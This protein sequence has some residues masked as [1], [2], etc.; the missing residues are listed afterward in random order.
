[1]R[2]AI[3][4][5]AARAFR[6]G[7][8][9]GTSTREI[10]SALGMTKGNLYYYFR[11][12]EQ[13]LFACHDRSLDLMLGCLEEVERSGLPPEE[14]LRQLIRRHVEVMI[15]ELGGSAMALEFGSLSPPLL[16]RVIAKRDLY[17]AGFRRILA[18]GASSGRFR[19]VDP[20]LIALA[21]LGSINWVARWYRP[22]GPLQPAEIGEAFADYFVRGLLSISP[23]SRPRRDEGFARP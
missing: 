14:Q 1:M 17:E 21:I 3:L 18:R 2:E 13:I 16:R 20:K 9:H 10:A 15:D 11:D 7:G 22:E 5:T 4:R 8:F 12:K 23:P 19:P 6:Q